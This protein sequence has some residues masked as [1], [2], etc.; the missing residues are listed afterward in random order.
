LVDRPVEQ[1]LGRRRF[2]EVWARQLRWARLRRVSFSPPF[3]PG[4]LVGSPLPV[5]AF[6]VAAVPFWWAATG[7]GVLVLLVG[8]VCSPALVAAAGGWH[9]TARTA[10]AVLLRDLLLPALWIAAWLGND[11]VWRGNRIAAAPRQDWQVASDLAGSAYVPEP[12]LH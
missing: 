2:G 3:L 4:R 10:V 6:G 1:P 11:Y 8:L 12:D 9:S 5:A 7:G